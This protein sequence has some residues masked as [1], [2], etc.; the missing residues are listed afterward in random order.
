VPPNIVYD[1]TTLAEVEIRKDGQRKLTRKFSELMS[2][3][4]FTLRFGRPGKGND[5]G[6]VEELIWHVRRNFFVPIPRFPGSHPVI[7]G[8]SVVA[9]H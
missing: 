7:D 2:H 1:N 6:K 9:I 4:L 3:Y 8:V 5:K